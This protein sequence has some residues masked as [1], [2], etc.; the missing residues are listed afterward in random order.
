MPSDIK[1][2]AGAKVYYSFNSKG[3]NFNVNQLS[4]AAK[5]NN[6]SE[7]KCLTVFLMGN[8][9]PL[10]QSVQILGLLWILLGN[11]DFA[12]LMKK[13]TTDNSTED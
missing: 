3:D 7:T 5:S 12:F 11:A 2:L 4:H 13:K 10:K 6:T 9:W 8:R 1:L